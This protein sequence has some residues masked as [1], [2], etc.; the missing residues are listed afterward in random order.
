[1][2]GRI[3]QIAFAGSPKAEVDFRRIMLKRLHHTGSTL[4]S[5]MVDP[6]S[7]PEWITEE[8]VDV[9]AEEFERTGFTGALNFYRCLDLSW[10]LL[11]GAQGHQ[12][13]VPAAYLTGDRDVAAL[14]GAEAVRRLPE[15]VADLRA[16]TVLASCGHWMQQERPE[17]TNAALLEFVGKL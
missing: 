17:E 9:Y 1:M 5:R 7:L 12:I 4:R 11:V 13:E 3:V 8:D 10:E 16:V 6:A 2:E 14:L 15:S